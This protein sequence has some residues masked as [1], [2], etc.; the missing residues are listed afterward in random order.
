VSSWFSSLDSTASADAAVGAN[1]EAYVVL[2][3][4]SRL[5]SM[6]PLPDTLL[7]SSKVGAGGGGAG[8]SLPSS[9]V[10]VASLEMP[11]QGRRAA[12]S[13]A[14]AEE[15]DALTVQGGGIGDKA[16]EQGDGRE[17]QSQRRSVSKPAKTSQAA[18]VT[19]DD[20]I[21]SGN[22]EIAQVRDNAQPTLRHDPLA[23]TPLRL[24]NSTAKAKAALEVKQYPLPALLDAALPSQAAC[25]TSKMQGVA[26]SPAAMDKKA[27]QTSGG[28]VASG[29][30]TSVSNGNKGRGST[31]DLTRAYLPPPLGDAGF[32]EGASGTEAAAG[33]AKNLKWQ[34]KLGSIL[35]H[36]PSMPP[37][38]SQAVPAPAIAASA[39]PLAP[40][41]PYGRRSDTENGKDSE[42]G[43]QRQKG[44]WI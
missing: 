28:A 1:A 29:W 8:S 35:E 25:N 9:S 26:A 15:Q 5:A 13:R 10:A 3:S 42:K 22:M 32:C 37:A 21:R 39:E 38:P 31:G 16:K 18:S 33:D 41:A 23:L 6:R 27:P 4:L 40:L 7:S 34:F 36:P 44:T 20:H 43:K 12:G 14:D 19:P 11:L 17:G 30:G 2:A 24:S